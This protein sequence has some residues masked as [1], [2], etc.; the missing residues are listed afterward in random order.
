MKTI[1]IE[2]RSVYG[3]ILFYP[4]CDTARKFARLTGAKTLTAE[5]LAVIKTLG[6][7]IKTHAP[8]YSAA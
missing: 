7:T 2:P 6:Y 5:H 3:N 1:T 8:S 4:A